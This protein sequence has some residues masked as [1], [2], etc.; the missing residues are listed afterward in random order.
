MSQFGG[1]KDDKIGANAPLDKN[2]RLVDLKE[3]GDWVTKLKDLEKDWKTELAKAKTHEE[4]AALY[5][6]LIGRRGGA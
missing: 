3:F 4:Q 2:Q 6:D 1:H 5:R